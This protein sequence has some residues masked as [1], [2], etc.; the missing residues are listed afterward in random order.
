MI[1]HIKNI[2]FPK[3]KTNNIILSHNNKDIIELHFI[4]DLKTE[5]I[6]PLIKIHPYSFVEKEKDFLEQAESFAALLNDF[7]GDNNYIKDLIL[8][9]MEVLSKNSENDNLFMTNVLFF[10]KAKYQVKKQEEKKN[11][12]PVIRPINVFKNK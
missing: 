12:M 4:F 11:K 9:S 2:I 10:W 7:C 6:I 8:E 3:N 1:S 5:N